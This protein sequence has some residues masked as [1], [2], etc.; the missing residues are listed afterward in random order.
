[1]R[2]SDR[3]AFI[4]DVV[5]SVNDIADDHEMNDPEKMGAMIAL[6]EAAQHGHWYDLAERES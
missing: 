5:E 3:Q 2:Q 4:L 6:G 1:M